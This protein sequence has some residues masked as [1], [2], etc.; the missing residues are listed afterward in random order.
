MLLIP[1]PTH[2]APVWGVAKV[3]QGPC[4]GAGGALEVAAAITDTLSRMR[5]GT[6]EAGELVARARLEAINAL[7]D[8]STPFADK[9]ALAG[10][11]LLTAAFLSDPRGRDTLALHAE[12]HAGAL[13]ATFQQ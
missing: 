4:G 5:S 7:A 8:Q 13:S 3:L 2:A 12:E 6:L 10:G 11:I 1:P 9:D